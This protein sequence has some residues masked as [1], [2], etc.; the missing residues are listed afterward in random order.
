MQKQNPSPADKKN[1]RKIAKIN[2]LFNLFGSGHSDGK[3][4]TYFYA[5]NA[6]IRIS[7]YEQFVCF[8]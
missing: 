2:A 4:L 6:I 1:V 5:V 8:P 3:D 7:L